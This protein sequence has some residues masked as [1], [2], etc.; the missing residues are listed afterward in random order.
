VE[1]LY[2]KEQGNIEEIIAQISS[3]ATRPR[4]EAS[5]G[6]ESAELPTY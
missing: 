4:G 6:D 2:R 1:G 3:V 5:G